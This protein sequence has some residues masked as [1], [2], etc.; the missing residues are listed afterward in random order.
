M[1]G[2]EKVNIIVVKKGGKHKPHSSAWKVAYADFVTA[3]MAFFIVMWVLAL[4]EDIK[5]AIAAYFNNPVKSKSG[6]TNIDL[7][8][9]P[10]KPPSSQELA[11]QEK[12]RLQK[13]A[14][15]TLAE[16]RSNPEFK[17]MAKNVEIAFTPEGM[18]IELLNSDAFFDVGTATLK[19]IAADLL[20]QVGNL[21]T[22]IPNHVIIEGHTDARPFAGSGRGIGYDNYN[23]SSDRANAARVALIR[24]G[25]PEERLDAV[26]GFADKE[27]RN[28]ADPYDASNRR[29]SILVRYLGKPDSLKL[30]IP[31]T[32]MQGS[33]KK[34]K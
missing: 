5:A 17:D 18:K 12:Q 13:K 25:L 16:L 27:L 26:R 7:K 11:I 10:I 15:Q 33:V 6:S 1:A 22:D 28:S 21:L 31:Q 32:M 2:D 14:E 19:P 24:G 3:M 30:T 20:E 8:H 23:L 29:I 34:S 4:S 9:T